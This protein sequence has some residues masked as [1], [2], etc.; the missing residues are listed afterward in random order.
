MISKNKGPG[1]IYIIL[2]WEVA[3][4]EYEFKRKLEILMVCKFKI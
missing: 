3:T 1:V 2:N 4:Y